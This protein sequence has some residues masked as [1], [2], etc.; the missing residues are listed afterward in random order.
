MLGIPKDA[1]GQK[2]FMI[3]LLPV[4]LAAGYYQFFHAKKSE[5]LDALNTRYETLEAQNTAARAKAN[6]AAIRS[7]QQKV[8]MFEQHAKRLEE[9]IPIR[10]E[11]PQLLFD[12][13]SRARDAGV[14][15]ALMKP[16]GESTQQY[17]TEQTYAMRVIGSYHAIGRFLAQT[18]SLPRIVT[19]SD[20]RIAKPQNTQLSRPDKQRLQA[21]FKIHTYVIPPDTTRR[22]AGTTPTQ[23]VNAG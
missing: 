16:E 15:L 3:G 9:L 20:V 14:D 11:V 6:P 23:P 2:K 8:A 13:T 21:D 17:Y 4:L 5:E 1:E 18:G 12:I 10:E 19:S 22:P 7:L